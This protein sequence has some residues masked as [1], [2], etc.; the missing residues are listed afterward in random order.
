MKHPI[1]AT[2]AAVLI[3]GSAASAVAGESSTVSS[4]FAQYE[5]IRQALIDGTTDGIAVHAEAIATVARRLAANFDATAAG[6]APDKA[7]Q[8]EALLPK[9]SAAAETLAA[10]ASVAAARDAFYALSKPL[11]TVQSAAVG[12]RP[13]V[14]YCPMEKRSWLQPDEPVGNPY[15]PSMLRC[16]TVVSK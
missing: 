12:H 4:I 16:G 2:V 8:V 11:V 13:M 9:I 7:E 3:L 10:A 15:A 1:L 14:V 6:I 5:P